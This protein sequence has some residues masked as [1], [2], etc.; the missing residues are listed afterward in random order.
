MRGLVSGMSWVTLFALAMVPFSA[1]LLWRTKFG[2]RLRISGERPEA[3]AD[4]RAADLDLE[5]ELPF[6]RQAVPRPELAGL[7]ESLDMGDDA[8][9]GLGVVDWRAAGARYRRRVIGHTS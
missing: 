5:R 4:G 2:L 8:F 6:R 1:W 9:G 7:D 3:G